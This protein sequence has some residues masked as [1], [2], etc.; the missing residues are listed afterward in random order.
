LIKSRRNNFKLTKRTKMKHVILFIMLLL[1]IPAISNG[2]SSVKSVVNQLK[3]TDGYEGFYV[4]GWVIRMG[5]KLI[6]KNELDH[7]TRGLL[8]IA[9]GI[10]HIRVATT[11]LDLTKYNTAAIVKSFASKI[12]NKD[13]FEEYVSVRSEDTNLNILVKEHDDVITNLLIM[14]EDQGEISFIHLKTDLSVDDLKKISFRQLK[15]ESS[16]LKSS[17]KSI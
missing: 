14:S 1:M 8:D 11:K 9:K 2:Q 15:D 17:E 6:P 7:E 13:R 10:R 5:I 16:K 3:K 4:P 12:K